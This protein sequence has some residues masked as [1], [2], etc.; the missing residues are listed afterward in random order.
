MQRCEALN[1]AGCDTLPELLWHI[2][3]IRSVV[4][5]HLWTQCICTGSI[6]PRG[7]LVV[8]TWLHLCVCNDYEMMQNNVLEPGVV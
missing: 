8:A 3:W 2:N 7:V 1:A 5:G 6:V 4:A